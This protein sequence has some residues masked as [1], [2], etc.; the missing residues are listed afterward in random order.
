MR[1]FVMAACA[2]GLVIALSSG[3]AASAWASKTIVVGPG[4]SIQ[5]AINQASPGDTVL[6]KRGVY[7]QSV[8]IRTDGI[9][10]RGSGNSRRGT[11]LK[12]PATKPHTLCT[13]VFGLTG[14]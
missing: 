8:Q 7:H 2:A 6:L 13:G 14:V 10:L 11:V 9:T 3:T 1:R 5:A 4:H 12:P